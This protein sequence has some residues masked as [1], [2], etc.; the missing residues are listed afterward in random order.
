MDTRR[1]FLMAILAVALAALSAACGRSE[2]PAPPI[3]PTSAPAAPPAT[4]DGYYGLDRTLDISIRI[5]PE[6]WDALR[7]QGRTLEDVFAEIAEKRLSAPFSDV[8]TWF[9]A[10]VTV[11]GESFARVGVRKKGFVGSQSDVKPSLKIRFD[12]YADGQAL[13]GVFERMTL[14]NS[15]QD[16]SLIGTCLSF[17][18]FAAAG[19]PA[20]RCNFA[21]VSVNG[22]NL[23]LYVNVEDI[24]TSMLARE[25]A[26][27]DGNLY[28]GT[29]SDF[30]P[31]YRGTF[32]KKT[33][34]GANDWSDVDA[35]TAALLDPSEAGW[36]AMR[37]GVDIDRFLTFWS[38]EVIIAHWDGYAG[39]RNNY[40]FYREPEGAFAFIPWGVDQVFSDDEKDPNP[41][42]S[43]TEPPPSVLANG[44][45]ANRM[46]NDAEGRAAYVARLTETLDAVWDEDALI[47]LADEMAA[48]VQ[49]RAL[50]ENRAAAK[51]EAERVR[52]FILGRRAT[53][54]ADL[55]PQPPEWREED[56]SSAITAGGSAA[57]TPGAMEL[58]FSAEWGTSES[59][60]PFAEGRITRLAFDGAELPSD[61]LGA[62]AGAAGQDEIDAFGIADAASLNVLG[63]TQDGAIQGLTLTFPISRLAAGET[64]TFGEDEIAGGV[65]RVPPGAEEPNEFLPVAS[66]ALTLLEAS[67]NR[68]A[69]ISAQFN[70]ALGDGESAQPPPSETAAQT[71][72]DI[73]AAVSEV[74]TGLIINE[75]AS[76]GDPLDW[77]ELHNKS[78]SPINLADFV[79]ADD[80]SDPSK[81]VPFPPNMSLA[82]GAYLRIELD[83][84]A[85]PGF[86]LGSDEELGV[87]TADGALV[88]SAD[89][90]DGD[91]DA[92][93][94]Y[95][96]VPNATGDFKTVSEPTP[97]MGN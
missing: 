83:K 51:K 72:T 37:N 44:A 66:G 80:L 26:D 46:Y 14:N 77:F 38:V 9:Q 21:T 24:E 10:D 5:A 55:R 40:W 70:G 18:V 43:V 31:T 81:R 79:F 29:V 16:E 85:W 8:Y 1:I 82:P 57:L 75:V 56:A 12:K 17:A 65:W 68:G 59:A 60:N 48:I 11:D 88:D 61:G 76:K 87:W 53:I 50:P 39:N 52:E 19:Q 84:E 89:W 78:D 28:E 49:R 6:D 25:F 92:G 63:L 94:S 74:D 45:L 36:D 41:F 15:L 91:A 93:T 32:E 20:P 35:L 30:V 22:E 4:A 90:S 3:A 34:N 47:A 13:G 7:K 23:G 54:L 62:I 95:A 86:A 69:A 96:R 27:P 71:Q 73:A 67:A 58:Q 97:G 2:A 42:D 33:N 64:L